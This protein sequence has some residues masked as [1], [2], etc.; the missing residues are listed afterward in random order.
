MRLD[1]PETFR[2]VCPVC[3]VRLGA[4]QGVGLGAAW[5]QKGDDVLEGVLHCS[6]SECRMEYP[7]V[8]GIPLLLPDLRAWVAENGGA[9]LARSDLT[10]PL[11]SVLGDCAG[12]ASAVEAGRQMISHYGF[13]HW[14]DRVAGTEPGDAAAGAPARFVE[15]GLAML[16]DSLPPGPALDA[17]CG[18]GRATA[19]TAARTGRP[20]MGVDRNF[21]FLR[22][23]R[24]A[25]RGEAAPFPLRRT[26]LVYDRVE[27]RPAT[28]PAGGPVEFAVADATDPPFASGTFALAL[29]L[30]VLD[31]VADPRGHL[32][33][34]ARVL[35]PGGGALFATPF[36]WSPGATPVEGWIGG[37]SQRG[38]GGGRGEPVLRAL[39]TPGAHPASVE[40]FRMVAEDGGVQWEIRLHD[41][42]RMR[43]V[44][45]MVAARR[46]GT[47]AAEEG[48]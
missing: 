45:H 21:P 40:G 32:A 5:R 22:L 30:Q 48:P 20:A 1:A 3:R 16:G 23:A 27:V 12:P 35:A 19:E 2:F 17:G 13:G 14:G 44:A 18:A 42:A 29:S 46:A 4:E 10:A 38:P 25:A 8:D 7:V 11:E 33:G 43:Y 6:A 37:H 34:M 31:C 36:D 39:L 9:L 26:G 15:R 24:A 28:P 47:T 41:R